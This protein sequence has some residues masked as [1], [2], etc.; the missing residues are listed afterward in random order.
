MDEGDIVR[1]EGRAGG[2]QL[3]PPPVIDATVL[4][5]ISDYRRAD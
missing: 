2:I 1:E 5:L 3:S 4:D